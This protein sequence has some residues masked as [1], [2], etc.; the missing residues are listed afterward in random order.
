MFNNCLQSNLTFFNVR[1]CQWIAIVVYLFGLLTTI[2]CWFIICLMNF[3]QDNFMS[4]TILPWKIKISNV[5]K[6]GTFIRPAQGCACSQKSIINS[7]PIIDS[8]LES[9]TFQ[10]TCLTHKQDF[11]L[12]TKCIIWPY[13]IF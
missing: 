12:I 13:N 4:T 2:L 1:A 7:R 5:Q 6:V 9:E 10:K 8:Y 11:S 3:V